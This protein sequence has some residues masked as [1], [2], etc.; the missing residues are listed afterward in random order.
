MIRVKICGI[1]EIETALVAAE[2]GAD[3]IGLVFAP[4]QRRVSV[5]QARAISAAM[6]PFVNRVGVFADEVPSRVE[7]VVTACGLDVIQLHG[8]EPPEVCAELRMPILKAIRV[9]DASSL[10]VMGAYHVAA[11]LLDTYV[12]GVAGG[13][14]R[15]FDWDLAAQAARS[16]RIVLSGGLTPDNVQEALSRVRPYG[17]DV[18]SGV[19]TNGRKDP[20][21]IRAFVARVR[22]WECA[23]RG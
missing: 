12:A 22:D 18:S 3:A 16:A 8:D 21:K 9:K 4:S 11:F 6:P 19:E 17:V 7:E 23:Q 14:G 1:S 2:A 15:P 10:E 20:Q 13:S 5:A